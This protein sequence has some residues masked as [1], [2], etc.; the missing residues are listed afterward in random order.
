MFDDVYLVD[1]QLSLIEPAAIDELETRIGLP[2]PTGYRQL[3][4]VLGV[5]TYCDLVTAFRPH[6]VIEQTESAQ[7]RWNAYFFWERGANILTKGQI[8]NSTIIASTI[9]GD[10]MILCPESLD[11]IYVLPRHDDTIYRLDSSFS[12][13]LDWRSDNGPVVTPPPFR[14]F[15]PWGD[16][17]HIELF[18]AKT[19]HKIDDVLNMASDLLAAKGETKRISEPNCDLLFVKAVAG[20]LQFTTG[21]D[22]RIG[23]RIDYNRTYSAAIENCVA[24]LESRDFYVTGRSNAR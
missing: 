22:P 9:D 13:P 23:I 16:R 20:R 8:L 24:E 4:T 21:G 6:D 11:Y 17:E 1:D 10:E 12:D 5:G 2:V 15:E 19:H 14:Y 18:T 7:E 3:L